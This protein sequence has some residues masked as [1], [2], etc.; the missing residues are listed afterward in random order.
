MRA[1][2]MLPSI[3]WARSAS[4]LISVE[5]KRG[6]SAADQRLDRR[7]YHRVC[8][9]GSRMKWELPAM[10]QVMMMEVFLAK[11]LSSWSASSAQSPARPDGF[12]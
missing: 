11:M 8:R 3:M 12:G 5:K 4:Q 6:V 10:G 1:S 7:L 9:P 2:S